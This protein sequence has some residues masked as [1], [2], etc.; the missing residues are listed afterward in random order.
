MNKLRCGL[1]IAL[2]T[3][4]LAPPVLTGNSSRILALDSEQHRFSIHGTV[5]IRGTSS[6]HVNVAIDESFPPGDIHADGVWE[7]LFHFVPR[8][9]RPRYQDIALDLEG[10]T[11]IY[12][13]WRLIV[14]S[15]ERKIVLNLM[16]RKDPQENKLKLFSFDQSRVPETVRINRGLA[17]G[18]YR[19]VMANDGRFW[20]CGNAGGTCS[21]AGG[22]GG[23]DALP[24]R[25][26]RTGERSGPTGC[27]ISD[28]GATGCGVACGPGTYPCCHCNEGCRCIP[29]GPGEP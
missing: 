6:G 8:K 13:S 10:A 12:S 22:S 3:M 17:L 29:S 4:L 19:G 28:G 15:D 21:L 27:S 20:L 24:S 7:S 2:V 1:L 25:T 11:V 16:F 5:K 9:T 26:N 18:H 23:E 14:L